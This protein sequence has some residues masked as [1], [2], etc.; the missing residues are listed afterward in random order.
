MYLKRTKDKYFFP[1]KAR[2]IITLLIIFIVAGFMHKVHAQASASVSYT[3]VVTEDMLANRSSDRGLDMESNEF[4]H[5][6]RSSVNVSLQDAANNNQDMHAFEAELSPEQSPAI[7]GML[8][9]DFVTSS[10]EASAEVQYNRTE[11][12]SGDYLVVMEFN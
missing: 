3:I 2:P 6:P 5:S 11:K 8:K 10:E 1:M 4:E 9:D 12:D 7:A